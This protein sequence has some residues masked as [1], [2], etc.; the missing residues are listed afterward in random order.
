MSSLKRVPLDMVKLGH[1]F[2]RGVGHDVEEDRVV[3]SV[4]DLAHARGL[5]VV[6]EGVESWAEGARLCDLGC[7]RAHG[8]LFAGPQRPDR[9][10]WML[11]RGVGWQATGGAGALPSD[12]VP[13]P[14]ETFTD[15]S[16]EA[17]PEA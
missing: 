2:V 13:S 11:A 8:Y 16:I 17:S 1:A 15:A 12:A 9:A 14:R 3:A 6:A 7:D 5:V 10:R 4:I